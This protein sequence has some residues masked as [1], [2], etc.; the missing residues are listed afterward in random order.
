MYCDGQGA[1]SRPGCPALSLTWFLA[2]WSHRRETRSLLR[3][4][5]PAASSGLR[6]R[7]SS[8][9]ASSVAPQHDCWLAASSRHVLTLALAQ[10][11]HGRASLNPVSK[12]ASLEVSWSGS[13]PPPTWPSDTGAR[14]VRCRPRAVQGLRP[15]RS[16]GLQP[17]LCSSCGCLLSASNSR[18]PRASS[19]RWSL[20]NS[21]SHLGSIPLCMHGVSTARL[22]PGDESRA[23]LIGHLLSVLLLGR[24]L[25]QEVPSSGPSGGFL[26]WPKPAGVS[27]AAS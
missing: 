7:R 15:V 3:F 4:G 21:P 9:D 12:V 22:A 11:S 6:L 13:S 18:S 24:P 8:S 17:T 2:T 1:W 25:S 10:A 23:A 5:L 27:S 19:L 26:C 14:P 20:P 16:R